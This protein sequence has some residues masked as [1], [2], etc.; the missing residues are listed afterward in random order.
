MRSLPSLLNTVYLQGILPS[1]TYGL[2]I[3]GNGSKMHIEKLEDLHRKAAR[4]IHRIK[5]NVPDDKVLQTA[6]WNSIDWMYKY[7][8]SCLTYKIIKNLTPE[9]LSIWKPKIRNNRRLR[10]NHRTELPYFQKMTY[11]KS[12][13]YRASSLWNQLPNQCTDKDTL[14]A[15]KKELKNTLLI[16]PSIEYVKMKILFTTNLFI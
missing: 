11:K 12:F 1:A 4:F 16:F 14:I 3:W 10:N 2:S 9:T 7:R 6:G 13:A 5:K 15:F 8:I